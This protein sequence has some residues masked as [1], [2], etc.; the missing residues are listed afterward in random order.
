MG[1]KYREY[2]PNRGIS[3]KE[4]QRIHPVWRGVGCALMVLIP[5]IAFAGANVLLDLNGKNNWFPLPAD[6][7]ARPGD[8]LYAYIADPMIHIK[9]IIMLAI[10]AVL[11]GL[12]TWVSFIVIGS[13]GMS[14]KNDPY[15][16]APV[17]RRRR[18]M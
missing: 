11:F 7:I 9:L 12:I 10:A 8:F 2:Q 18:R 17:R 1:A 13:F 4:R 16:V 14:D 3:R 15:Y 6:L 5:I